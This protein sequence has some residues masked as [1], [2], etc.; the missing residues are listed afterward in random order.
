MNRAAKLLVLLLVC[1]TAAA[2]YLNLPSSEP[3][4]NPSPNPAYIP[5]PGDSF[6]FYIAENR[7][8]IDQSLQDY[9]FSQ[10]PEPFGPAYSQ[11]Q[12][13][14]MRAP[15]QID[16]STGR[17]DSPDANGSK[18]FLLVH[19]LSDSPYLLK[20]VATSLAEAYP[21]ALL[22]GL[23]NPGHST[24]PGDLL[25]VRREDWYRTFEY[26][27]DSFA[28]Q[29]DSLFVVG[30]S[31][32][33]ALA[34][35]YADQNRDA[36]NIN[37]LILLSP[38]LETRDRRAFLSPWLKIFLPWI[39]KNEDVDAVKYESF[40]TNAAAE[41]YHL[42]R[43]LDSARIEPLQLPILMVVSGDDTTINNQAT[44]DFFCS[45]IAVAGRKMIWYRSSIPEAGPDRT[46]E[47]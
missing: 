18:G 29:V 13:L 19:G 6:E 34:L 10:G 45:S 46:C 31:N 17:C 26:G 33:S 25:E 30:Y 36:N 35:K 23:L 32:G 2:Y 28:D 21:C 22:R 24:V 20:Q 27:V 1:L 8:R 14:N 39:N 11:E 40:P 42:T 43:E 4:F 41:F 47:G 12:V 7:R 5:Q 9:Y 15:Y 3:R 16:P 44:V 37:G 38:G